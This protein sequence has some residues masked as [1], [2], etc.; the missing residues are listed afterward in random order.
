MSRELTHISPTLQS[1]LY[2]DQ[3]KKDGKNIYNFGLGENNVKQS[4]FY[5]QKI[6]EY[7][8]K[9]EYGSSEGIPE[10]NKTLKNMYNNDKTDYD[11]I[12]TNIFLV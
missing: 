11:T 2:I 9:K 12:P 3:L 10:L 7:A 5:I 8:H 1:K 4:P 6:Q